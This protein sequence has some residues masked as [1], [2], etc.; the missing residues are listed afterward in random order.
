MSSIII[1]ADSS[2]A[3][4]AIAKKTAEALGYGYLG[5]EFLAQLAG[6]YNVS[7]EK[8]AKALDE[9]TSC[10][11]MP[12]KKRNLYLAYIQ[13][14]ALE[15]FLEDNLVCAGLAAHLYVRDIPHVL[16]IRILSDPKILANQIA[17]EKSIAPKKARKILESRQKR[18][19]RW[20]E[21]NFGLNEFDPSLYDMAI[22]LSQIETEKA[23]E[24]LK[25]MIGYRKFQPMTY[26]VNCLKD[27]A[28]AG[29]V[30][31]ALWPRFPRTQ[32]ESRDGTVVLKPKI[33]KR[34]KLEQTEALKEL[35]YKIAGVQYVEVHPNM[36]FVRKSADSD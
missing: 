7:E 2:P 28:L 22:S 32:V 21:R 25:D 26:S 6:Q 4:Q 35:T 15:R 8:L 36:N 31:A 14:A 3:G 30:R 33:L 12:P 23:V 11:G 9:N 29:K 1:S 5:P 17:A 19:R 24:V 10:W 16:M 34:N 27:K 13:A 20:S 18:R